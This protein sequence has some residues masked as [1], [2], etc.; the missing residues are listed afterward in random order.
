M[1]VI[2]WNVPGETEESQEGPQS[3]Q[4]LLRPRFEPNES[5]NQ[6]KNIT[7]ELT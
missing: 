2:S 5:Q 3:G 6:V 4:L 7:A 1:E